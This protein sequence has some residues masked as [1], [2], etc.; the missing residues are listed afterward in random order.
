MAGLAI[1]VLAP[2]VYFI[3]ALNTGD[4]LWISPVFDARPQ[5]IVIHCFG[6]D[7]GFNEGT[8]RFEEF[9][10]LVNQAL[11]GSKRWDSLSL[12]DTTY[13]EYQNHP[14]MMVLELSYAQPFRVHSAYKFFSRINTIIIPLEGRHAQTNAVFGRRGDYP[15]AGS[16]HVKTTAPLVEYLAV[17][18]LCPQP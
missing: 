5:S 13:Q 4:L 17:N 1:L 10:D 3:I 14:Q 8:P 9:T 7:I 18:G 16:F 6:E 15:A 2:I 11:S 12:S